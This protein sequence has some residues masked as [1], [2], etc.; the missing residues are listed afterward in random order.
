MAKAASENKAAEFQAS[1]ERWRTALGFVKTEKGRSLAGRT[2]LVAMALQT[3]EN[4]QSSQAFPGLV[5]LGR[6]A[7]IGGKDETVKKEAKKHLGILESAG[8]I[9][10]GSK[11]FGGSVRYTFT[12]PESVGAEMD[13]AQ[14]RDTSP[15]TVADSNMGTYDPTPIGGHVSPSNMGT[16]DPPQYGDTYPPLTSDEPSIK[17]TSDIEPPSAAEPGDVAGVVQAE[18]VGEDLDDEYFN[19]LPE[20]EDQPSPPEGDQIETEDDMLNKQQQEQWNRDC[21]EAF[22]ALAPDD[23]SGNRAYGS[24]KI[25]EKQVA[26]LPAGDKKGSPAPALSGDVWADAPKPGDQ[27]F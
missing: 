4:R 25:P 26:P 27:P 2:I 6:R 15:H 19:Q 24:E 8:M 21:D 12:V 20:P 5:T 9:V 16:Y 10:R 17:E 14:C 18:D 7:G 23:R 1:Q 3:F 22:N 11:P 13:A